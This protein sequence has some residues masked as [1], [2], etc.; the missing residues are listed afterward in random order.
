MENLNE[1]KVGDFIE[2]KSI[3]RDGN[4]KAIRKVRGFMN[5]KPVVTFI[6]WKFFVVA[7]HEV[8]RIIK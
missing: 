2:F 1:I 3:T 5:G 8:I 6:G 4:Y 7:P